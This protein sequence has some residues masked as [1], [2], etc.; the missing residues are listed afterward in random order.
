M[1]VGHNKGIEDD[2]D[3]LFQR[4]KVAIVSF[5]RRNVGLGHPALNG[6]ET[7]FNLQRW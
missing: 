5:A 7:G 2:F 4:G 6:T 1:Y 3:K